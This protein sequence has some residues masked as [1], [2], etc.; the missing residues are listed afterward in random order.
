M[1]NLSNRVVCMPWPNG[2]AS[3]Q[4]LNPK[5]STCRTTTV[6][7][8]RRAP[9]KRRRLQS[10]A[11]EH[12]ARAIGSTHAPRS[13]HHESDLELAATRETD[14]LGQRIRVG[15]DPLDN[16]KGGKTLTR[17]LRDIAS[18]PLMS[19]KE[20]L[21][22]AMDIERAEVAHWVAIL[23]CHPASR[24]ALDSLRR[25]LVTAEENRLHLPQLARIRQLLES[26]EAP[27]GQA[28]ADQ[29]E[30]YRSAC[31]SLAKAIRLADYDRLW[32]SHADAAVR[33]FDQAAGVV[34]PQ[35][36]TRCEGGAPHESAA[37]AAIREAATRSRT[38]KDRFVRSNLRLVVSI[39]L[40]YSHGRLPLIDVIQEGNIGLMKAVERFDPARGFRLSTYACWWIRH[41]INRAL[42]DK[43]R[44]VRIPVHLQSLHRRI[45]HATQSAL[46]RGGREPTLAELERETG[47]AHDKLESASGVC[48][49]APYSL[50]QSVGDDGRKLLDLLQDE[51][52][53]SAHDTLANG[54]ANAV[55]RRLLTALTPIESNIIRR[56]FGLDDEDERTFQEIGAEHNLSRERIRQLQEQA[57]DKMREQMNRRAG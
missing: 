5:K 34:A 6:D 20:E 22:T 32:I 35:S 36:G 41:A 46:T 52:S 19:A 4:P 28:R 51:T 23:L 26:I 2:L 53:P 15:G 33:E 38:V 40:R 16:Q 57:L 18:F 54:R 9:A 27:G 47:I 44:V 12:P 50:D 29:E 39:A 11:A 30:E 49:D 3:E 37:H 21:E 56:R 24:L 55:V 13:A 25:D 45:Q 42:A 14:S 43:G 10:A 31:T 1:A 8:S 48:L 17:Y 7:F